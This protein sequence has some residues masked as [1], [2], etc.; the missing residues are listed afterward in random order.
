MPND[1]MQVGSNGIIS[2]GTSAYNPV[3]NS[4]FPGPTGIYLI[5]PYWDD[6]NINNGG[7]ISYEAFESGY[8]LEQVNDFLQRRGLTDFEGTWMMVVYYD[9]VHP[10]TGTGEVH[11]TY[12]N[13]FLSTNIHVHICITFSEY[14]SSC[15]DY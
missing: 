13:L 2:F 1:K 8:L 5:A 9:S 12:T 3:S 15:Y 4:A 7:T 6:I 14:I 11:G 10:F